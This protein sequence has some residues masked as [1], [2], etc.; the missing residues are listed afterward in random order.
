MSGKTLRAVLA[1]VGAGALAVALWSVWPRSDPMAARTIWYVD[2][3][4][5]EAFRGASDRFAALPARNDRDG[6]RTVFPAWEDEGGVL[7]FGARYGPA[8]A[9]LH[10]AGRS[11]VSPR[12]LALERD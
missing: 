10:E 11:V 8:I 7:R 5:G 12:T 1:C 3:E 2:V 4:T 6:S 9:E